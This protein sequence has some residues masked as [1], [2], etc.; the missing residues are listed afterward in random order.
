L[1]HTQQTNRAAKLPKEI[2]MRLLDQLSNV[3]KQHTGDS[4]QNA[5]NATEHF[6]QVAQAGPP[7]GIAEGLSAVVRSDQ[8][9]AFDFL[10]SRA[11]FPQTH[12][13]LDRV[14]VSD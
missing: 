7:N 14:S 2:A 12:V 9:P 5:A 4:T 11:G 6:D 1:S 3:L 13:R 8:T 10:A